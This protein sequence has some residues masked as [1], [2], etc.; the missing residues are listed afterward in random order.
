[1]NILKGWAVLAAIWIAG[2]TVVSAVGGDTV[3]LAGGG[4]VLLL[5]AGLFGML[6]EMTK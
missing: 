6:F 1:M 4:I 5:F 3:D 2:I